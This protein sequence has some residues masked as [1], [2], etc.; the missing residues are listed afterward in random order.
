MSVHI[1]KNGGMQL[2]NFLLKSFG[3]KL[4]LEYG[5]DND[6]LE[7][8]F[9]GGKKHNPKVED[10]SKYKI[11]HGHFLANKFDDFNN[12]KLITFLRDPAQRVISNYY[13]FKRNFYNNSPICHM[14]R[15]GL[16]LEEYIEL[17]SSKNVQSFFLANKP[18]DDFVFV[19][20][21]EEYENSINL[22]KKVLDI[23]FDIKSQ[24]F[25]YKKYIEYLLKNKREKVMRFDNFS[26]NK[27]SEKKANKYDVN[28]LL[29]KK[30]LTNNEQ[31][32]ELYYNAQKKFNMM[33]KI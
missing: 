27:N 13:F 31:D 21:I 12:I 4:Y 30:I 26:A 18:L 19:G 8:F 25:Y 29:M 20:I 14:I 16:T 11:V 9:S 17:D 24:C 5:K 15:D 32:Y 7:R 33:R 10:Y 6:I 22:M 2:K 28:S 23:R 3:Q 1:H